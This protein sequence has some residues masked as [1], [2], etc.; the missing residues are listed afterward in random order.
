[1][2][3]RLLV[4]PGLDGD[5]GLLRSAEASLFR[6]F[7]PVWF[8]HRFDTAAGGA[9]GLAERA[10]AVLDRDAEG[11]TPAFVCG[12][13]FGGT[14][15]L[16]LARMAPERVRG[17]ILLS[18]FGCYPSLSSWSGRLGLL[19]WRVLGDRLARRVLDIWRPLGAPGALGLRC[20]TD[21]RRAYLKQEPVHLPGY[22]G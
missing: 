10:L 19:V 7:R 1:M 9:E 8:D 16:T 17:L 11:D 3:P 15:A 21:V 5:P 6:A 22:R 18:T 2:K 20:P 12:E 14:V 13:S 4:I